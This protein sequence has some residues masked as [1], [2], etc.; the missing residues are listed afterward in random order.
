MR[1]RLEPPRLSF[2]LSKIKLTLNHVG[3][4]D[5]R[6]NQY[7]VDYACARKFSANKRHPYPGSSARQN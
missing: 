4:N 7:I 6:Y 3:G 5:T 2:Q 1:K